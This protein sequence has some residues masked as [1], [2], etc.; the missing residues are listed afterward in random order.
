VTA[1][2]WRR[3]VDTLPSGLASHPQCE[4]KA[5][6]L[7]EAV[8]GLDVDALARA[9]PDELAELVRTPP[10]V[11]NW[12]SEVKAT[13]IM[14][15]SIDACF[16]ASEE[17]FLEHVRMGNVKM[18]SSPL[19]RALFLVVSPARVLRGMSARWTALHR[20]TSFVP[21]DTDDA[22]GR[23][24]RLTFPSRLMPR[25]VCRL[26]CVSIEVA[27]ALAGAHEPRVELRELA[28]THATFV[29]TWRD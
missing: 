4:Q 7:R 8:R 14:L 29:G 24:F 9:L 18:L 15:A 25:E 20:G 13:A 28:E 22:R 10:P 2:R 16:A 23:T 19:Y 11:S 17:R 3:Y 21:L 26:R 6:I 5:S 27:L 1:E 12:V